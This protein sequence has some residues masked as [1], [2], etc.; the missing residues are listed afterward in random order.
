M[1]L[2]PDQKT[3]VDFTISPDD[4]SLID[5]NMNKVVEPGIFDVM[6][7]PSSVETSSVPLEVVR[8]SRMFKTQFCV[9]GFAASNQ[10]TAFAV[11]QVNKNRGGNRLGLSLSRESSG[12]GFC[13]RSLL[14]G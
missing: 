9:S 13:R 2:D 5:V 11:R 12:Q 14:I 4:L 10:G 7:G 1:T 8:Q 3:T 6:V